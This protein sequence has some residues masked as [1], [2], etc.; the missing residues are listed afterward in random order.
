MTAP[1][2][3]QIR[4]PG[5]AVPSA[6]RVRVEPD[7]DAATF[8][9]RVE[10][11][12]HL[13]EPSTTV[14]LH[15]HQLEIGPPS[16]RSDDG[17]TTTGTVELDAAHQRAN[18]VFPRALAVG[19]HTLEL[20]FDGVLNDELAGFYR[21]TFTDE[22]GATATIA[23]TQLE[24]TDAR[25]AFPCFDE[26]AFKATFDVT[27]V[28]P[29]GMGAFSNS[30]PVSERT[31]E[32]G[33]REVR[34]AP[35]MPM[36]S[37]LVAFVVGP[38]EQTAVRD[39]D[40]VPLSVVHRAGQAHLTAFALDIGEYALRAF[41]EYFGIPYPGD[42]V[43]LVAIPDF[44]PGAMENLGCVTFREAELLV[45]PTTASQNELVRIASVVAHE[46][47]HM[48]FGDLVTMS[49]W[50]GLWLNEAFATFM[51]YVCCDGFR[52]EWK[53]WVRF[54]GERETGM[55]LDAVHT[56]RPIEYPVRS[57]D[58]A[59]AMA[60]PI[61]YQKGSSILRMLEQYLSADVLRDGVR[62]YL[63]THSHGNTVT[64]DLWASLEEVSG[65]PVGEIMDTWIHQGGHPIVSVDADSLEQRPFVLGPAEGESAI[66]SHWLVPVVERSLAGGD[67]AVQLLTEGSA[68][69]ECAGPVLVNAGGS[70]VYRTSY[71]PQQ[72]AAVV[73]HL[74]DLSEIERAVLVGDTT[75]LM[76]AGDRRVADVLS[77][78][79]NLGTQVEPRVWETVDRVFDFL[80]RTV[81]AEQRPLLASKVRALMGPVFETLGWDPSP[82]EDERAQV[83]RAT[84]VRRL[85]TTGADAGVR[86]EAV[87]RFDLGR[88]D[89]DLAQA[90]V[91]VVASLDRPGDYDEMIRRSKAA[92]DPQAER[93]YR[94]GVA[95]FTDE[96]LI[97]RAYAEAFD[98]FRLQD[99]P[100]LIFELVSNRVGGLAVWSAIAEDWDAVVDR[101]PG[102]MRALLGVGL[103]FQV[104]DTD[105]VAKV[106][107]FHRAHVVPA[108]QRMI[109]QALEWFAASSRLADAE[110][111]TLGE[112]L[113]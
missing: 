78:A 8:S 66:G 107:A 15:A 60:D 1:V 38:F 9:G 14:V 101:I 50:D 45:D 28:A 5:T 58:E 63:R 75:A 83:L 97:L 36:S 3:D 34:F 27:L 109:E 31:L 54:A 23:V 64:A 2:E 11:D 106:T 73:A 25:R 103:I 53:M 18:L 65:R 69:L 19:G 44:A 40:G 56:T 91:S 92:E 7:L 88:L 70:G 74:C 46:L 47:A 77:I 37:Y 110:R 61:T 105:T 35:T 42:K 6:Y 26:P 111:P 52:P 79:S 98:N 71:A 16:V 24:M 12:V 62:H 80:D 49:W 67:G 20:T 112:T 95:A 43:D 41:T 13:V 96:A 82:G 4:L 33:R 99:V 81:T 22:D 113:A 17:E 102:F 48:W 86:E 84:L 59:M 90:V 89:G 10:I 39:V 100:R 68:P 57:P 104:S 32:E 85:G 55:L 21:S 76:F 72:L 87:R 51:Q 108:G 29:P 94:N 93:R 30:A